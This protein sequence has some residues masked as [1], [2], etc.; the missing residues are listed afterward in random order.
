MFKLVVLSLLLAGSAHA[1]LP[2]LKGNITGNAATASALATDPAA[3]SA[4]QFVNDIAA[5]GTLSCAQPGNV[6]GN[7]ATATALAADPAA[8]SSPNFVRDIAANGTLTCAQPGDVTGNAATATALAANPSD[9]AADT[10]ATTIAA[11]GNLTCSTVTNAGLAGSIADGK[12]AS[13]YLY[14]DGTRP[15]TGNWNIGNFKIGIN[16][17]T[18]KAAIHVGSGTTSGTVGTG[19]LILGV[20]STTADI[21]AG[22]V[23][24]G[25]QTL[26]LACV[27]AGSLCGGNEF[28]ITAS[29]AINSFSWGKNVQI[30][31]G[32][33]ASWVGGQD[34]RARSA[35]N[36][37]FGF[38]AQTDFSS[39]YAFSIGR[40]GIASGTGASI[41]ADGTG[42][43]A[44]NSTANSLMERFNGGWTY[45]S[46]TS[47]GPTK[48]RLQSSVSTTDATVTT[49]H[50][51]TTAS[52]KNYVVE[53][54]IDARRT[55]GV[56]GA[57]GDGAGY[58]LRAF[59]KNVAGTVTVNGLTTSFSY[60]DQAG[61]DATIDVSSTAFRVR[62][63]G[64]AANDV[65]WHSTM[66]FMVI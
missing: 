43:A 16:Q 13:S 23:I 49:L 4:S 14:A 63:T 52:G 9:C 42:N 56:S 6:T 15:L 62:V 34:S 41:L 46:T 8:C 35:Y 10:Y 19:A 60:E 11:S 17:A 39:D 37:V 66:E 58:I 22:S 5:D 7:A 28:G 47:T 21:G 26:P 59:V 3:C 38:G 65:A 36:L 44:T 33:G 61:W 40:G 24:M 55:G 51:F 29:T 12:L 64:A 25:G 20:P 54:W 45:M 53:V 1:V 32:N 57:A 27:G 31:S 30:D 50:S 2:T 18:P 48:R